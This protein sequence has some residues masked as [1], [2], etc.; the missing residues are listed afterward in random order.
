VISEQQSCLFIVAGVYLCIEW[1]VATLE[2]PWAWSL[3]MNLSFNWLHLL[4]ISSELEILFSLEQLLEWVSQQHT[5]KVR[6]SSR[7]VN[8]MYARL[9][10]QFHFTLSSLPCSTNSGMEGGGNGGAT[11]IF[12]VFING[13]LKLENWPVIIEYLTFTKIFLCTQECACQ[14]NHSSVTNMF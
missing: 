11:L 8:S 7:Q 4:T 14:N 13:P 10:V 6:L 2:Y 5:L 9:K 1:D 3:Y 12:N